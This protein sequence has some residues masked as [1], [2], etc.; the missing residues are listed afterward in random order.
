LKKVVFLPK[1]SSNM[2]IKKIHLKNF[3][4][5]EDI[6]VDFDERLNVFIGVNGAGKSALLDAVAIL[7]SSFV[8]RLTEWKESNGN[9]Y[10]MQDNDISYGLLTKKVLKIKSV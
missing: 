3:R 5:F 8:S 7:L 2:V 10:F 9:I 6:T 1:N 4:L